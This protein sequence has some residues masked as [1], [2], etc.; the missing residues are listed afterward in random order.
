MAEADNFLAAW[1]AFEVALTEVLGRRRASGDPAAADRA[2]SLDQVR[3]R[4][5][6]RL[7]EA[8]R[9]LGAGQTTVAG[10][11]GPLARAMGWWRQ[12]R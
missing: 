10:E 3:L 2:A 5:R 6:G 7:E 4:L 8:R 11:A 9:Q 12:K 1:S